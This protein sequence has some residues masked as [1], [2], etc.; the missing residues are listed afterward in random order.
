MILLLNF[1]RVTSY[2]S[3][4]NRVG[5]ACGLIADIA[6]LGARLGKRRRAY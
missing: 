3:D 5:E 2:M 1:L 4:S 6:L